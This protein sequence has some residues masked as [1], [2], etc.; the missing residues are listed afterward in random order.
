MKSKSRSLYADFFAEGVEFGAAAGAGAF[1]FEAAVLVEA[2][3]DAEFLEGGG[4]GFDELFDAVAEAGGRRRL[5]L[6][7]RVRSGEW[8]GK[9]RVQSVECRMGDGGGRH[10]GRSFRFWI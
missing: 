5:G 7:C 6:K 2:I 10:F 3:D 8:D 9:C 1:G 4:D